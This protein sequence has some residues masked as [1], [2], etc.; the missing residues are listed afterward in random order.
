MQK[1]HKTQVQAD[2]YSQHQQV[3]LAEH[4]LKGFFLAEALG[5]FKKNLTTTC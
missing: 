3:A 2:M 5:Y 4:I 1:L